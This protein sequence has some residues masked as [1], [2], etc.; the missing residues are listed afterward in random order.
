MHEVKLP[1]GVFNI[2]TGT[3]VEAGAPLRCA[4]QYTSHPRDMQTH[5]SLAHSGAVS[6]YGGHTAVLRI[7][8]K[9]VQTT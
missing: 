1:P 7:W 2:I 5:S 3:G 9:D 8:M 4:Q 6:A